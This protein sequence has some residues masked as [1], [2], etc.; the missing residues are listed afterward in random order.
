LVEGCGLSAA[1]AAS[2]ARKSDVFP[3]PLTPISTASGRG[4][5]PDLTENPF[6]LTSIFEIET[7]AIRIGKV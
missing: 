3:E 2:T 7:G 1:R 4:K 6:P 5:T